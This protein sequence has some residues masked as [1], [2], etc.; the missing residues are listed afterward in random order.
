MENLNVHK[1]KLYALIVAA[2][3]FIALILPWQTVSFALGGFGGGSRSV[4]GLR[5]WGFLSLLGIGAVVVASLLGDKTKEYD[6]TFKKV[7]MGGFGAI[8]IG[9]IIYF[10]R[11]RSVGGAGYQGVSNKAGFGLWI[12]ILAGIVGLLWVAG[13]VKMPENKPPTPPQ[14]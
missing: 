13:L 12:D 5:G 14:S 7:A 4:N 8:A 10:I 9:A 2:L 11:I 1:Q 6:A 3:A